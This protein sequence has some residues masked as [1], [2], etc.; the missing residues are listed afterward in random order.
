[1]EIRKVGLIGRGAVGVLYGSL[2]MDKLGRERVCMIGDKER[3]TRYQ[4]EPVTLNGRVCDFNYVS[5]PGEFGE[6]DLL[7]IAVKYPAL[8]EALESVKGF[9][10]DH[11]VVLSLLNGITSEEIT[12]DYLK[13]GIVLHSIAQ[14]M[15]SVKS[16]QEV[17]YTRTGEI[18]IG[19][20]DENKKPQ[21]EMT[22]SFFRETGISHHVA[23]DI[24]HEQW[25]KLMLNCG[26]NQ[27]CAVYDV[28]YRGC[29]TGGPYRQLFRDVMEEVRRIASLEGI[30]LGEDEVERWMTAMDGL[31]ADAMPSMRQD[32][33]AGNKT[34]VDLFSRTM[35]ELAKKHKT[36]APMNEELY[37]KIKKLEAAF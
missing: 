33:L 6:V 31:A 4:S 26:I 29:Q 12:E 16:G 35:M 10:G 13:K 20:P 32:M 22:A 2:L 25:S 19:T 7:L 15:D 27:I 3:V 23:E 17:T 34:E 8:L 37:D 18:V 11:T 30:V 5:D 14:L 9:V 21:L 24:I 28:P 36:K 1:M